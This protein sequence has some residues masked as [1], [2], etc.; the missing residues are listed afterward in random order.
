MADDGAGQTG[1]RG[2]MYEPLSPSFYQASPTNQGPYAL[3]TAV[4]LIIITGLTLTV[5]FQT[6]FAIFRRPRRDDIALGAALVFALGYTI[7]LCQAVNRGLGRVAS[8]LTTHQVQL[9]SQ[10]SLASAKASATILIIAIEPKGS[11]LISLYSVLA[12]V[13]L[14]AVAAVFAVALQCK[15]MRWVMGP[16]T[17]DTCIDQFGAQ[18]GIRL[19]D[20]AIDVALALLPAVMVSGVQMPLHKRLVVSF[21]F[22]FRLVTPMLTAISLAMLGRFYDATLED[23]PFEAVRP[24]I[25]TSFALN[26]SIITAC[27]LSIKHFLTDWAA[28]VANA[29]IAE[30]YELQNSSHGYGDGQPSTVRSFNS[31]HSRRRSEDRVKAVRDGGPTYEYRARRRR[32][33][34]NRVDND[35]ESE[36]GLTDGILQTVDYHIEFKGAQ[37]RKDGS[38]DSKR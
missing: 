14:W 5:K 17:S 25:W 23:R 29:G 10:L 18:I 34:H 3:L 30:T 32:D 16:S 1:P 20:I 37:H 26:V 22:G 33:N 21:M 12:I 31:P 6:V 13:A 36:R 35:T 27:L 19:V 11:M 2:S 4:I 8:E 38:T 28:G 24:S 7:A 9:L 15:P